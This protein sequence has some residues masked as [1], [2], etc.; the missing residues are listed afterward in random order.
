MS[1]KTY[2]CSKCGYN[3][4]YTS[5]IGVKHLPYKRN[6]PITSINSLLI[7][8]NDYPIPEQE[9]NI[10]EKFK[11]TSKNNKGLIQGYRQSYRNGVEKYGKW[12]TIFNLSMWSLVLIFLL[13]AGIIFM[14]YLPMLR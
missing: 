8:D 11:G 12:W 10:P 13:T 1:E 6:A 14:V 2:Y 4:R 5:K 9:H 3:H 7:H